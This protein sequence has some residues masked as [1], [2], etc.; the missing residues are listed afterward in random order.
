[1]PMHCPA[2]IRTHI[3]TS[4]PLNHCPDIDLAEVR[5]FRPDIAIGR[6]RTHDL[7]VQTAHFS[8]GFILEPIGHLKTSLNRCEFIIMPSTLE[9]NI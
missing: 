5:K 2:G 4:S 9:T 7:Q 8:G 6:I 3:S 1:M